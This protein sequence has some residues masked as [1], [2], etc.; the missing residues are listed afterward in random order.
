MM[1][2]AF[3]ERAEAVLA[4]FQVDPA[5]G[6]DEAEVEARRRVH[7]AN[8]LAKARPASALSILLHQFANAVTALLSAAVIVAAA[9]GDYLESAAILVV[10]LINTGLGFTTELKARRSIEGLRKLTRVP[11]RVVRG[12]M[13]KVVSAEEIVPGDVVLVEAGDLVPADLRVVDLS[14]LEVD[15]SLLTGEALPVTKI[16]DELPG[17]TLLADRTN[18]LYRATAV[19][20]GTGRGVAVATGANTEVGQIATM[21]AEAEETRTPLERRLNH[22]SI[23]LMWI[24]LV[25]AVVV[26]VVGILTG[27]AAY[28]MVQ[29]AIA[30]AVAAIPE[31]LPV[32]AVLTL[33][34]GVWRMAE[35][36][37]LVQELSAVEALGAT[38][39]IITDKT[40]TLT[41]N[42]MTLTGLVVGNKRLSL[43][44][45]VGSEPV[46]TLLKT[47]ALCTNATLGDGP[48]AKP[49]GDTMEVAILAA[50]RAAGL[51]KD[52]LEQDAPRQREV[53][54][55]T[56]SRMMA[57]FNAEGEDLLVAVKGAPE[58]VLSASSHLMKADGSRQPLGEA[59]RKAILD[60]NDELAGEG[61][62]LLGIARRRAGDSSEDPYGNL[63]F[64]GLVAFSDPP[65]AEIPAAI[66]ACKDAGLRVVMVTGDQLPTAC[67]IARAV[68][69]EADH[70]GSAM[71][72][73]ELRDL[74]KDPKAL[75]A[76]LP[77]LRVFSRVAPEEKLALVDAY[78]KS[79]EVVAMLGDGVNDAPAL[80]KAD[81]GVAMGRRGTQVARE[82]ADMVLRDDSFTTITAAVREGRVIF[83][84]IRKA[85]L[86]LLACNLAEVLIVSV[87]VVGGLPLPLTALQILFLNLLTDVFPALALGMGEGGRNVMQR[88]PRPPGED[89]IVRRHWMEICLQGALMTV[90]VL[91]AFTLSLYWL[92]LPTPEAVT[93]TFL[94]LATAQ[95][96]NVFT[97]RARGA[98]LFDNEVVRNPYIWGAFGICAVLIGAA[99]MVPPLASALRLHW[100]SGVEWAI[101]AGFGLLP[102]V[103]R[104]IL[105]ALRIAK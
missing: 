3:S 26:G 39:V 69:I 38:T 42:R 84:N 76:R 44:E 1:E 13:V 92:H 67:S 89:I 65:R 101:V 15:E 36:N 50:A 31:G 83:G 5:A 62:R 77:G 93:V 23:Q 35:R 2:N 14:A 22:F 87:A 52:A 95:L 29:T 21:V 54:F 33:A 80:K 12:G 25:L 37:A 82:A 48:Q 72:G 88:P 97:A 75:M 40:G 19:T 45:G 27:H 59:D 53:A 28:G 49:V 56:L 94:T 86:Y 4:G 34:R 16:T 24:T 90:G 6:L 60:R 30:L 79:G 17:N 68:G 7:G 55:D 91:A 103:L 11:A 73:A 81:V 8:L 70:D 32:V 58:A 66:A 20:R 64:L 104:E 100:L 85:V 74:L 63:E 57:T 71:P 9:F 102:L 41:E 61:L 43:K 47:A 105:R 46:R 51:E 99:L 10:I 78:Q 98:S 96:W 18:M